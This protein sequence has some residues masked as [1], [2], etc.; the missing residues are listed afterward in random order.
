[1][2]ITKAKALVSA[3]AVGIDPTTGKCLPDNSISSRLLP[4]VTND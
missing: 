1:M 3:P 2:D 4:E